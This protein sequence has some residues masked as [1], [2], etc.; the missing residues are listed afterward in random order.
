MRTKLTPSG[1]AMRVRQALVRAL[2]KEDS[3]PDR[4]MHQHFWLPPAPLAIAT[5]IAPLKLR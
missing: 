5:R 2:Q 3:T 1:V 4:V